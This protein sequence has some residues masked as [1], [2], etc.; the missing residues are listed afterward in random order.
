MRPTP[1]PRRNRVDPAL[2]KKIAEIRE[3]FEFF[4]RDN[5]GLIDFNEFRSL[6][7]TVNPEASIS[8][9]AEGFSMTD[10]NS[11][12]YVDLDEFIAWWRS[13]WWEY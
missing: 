6:L 2:D 8:Q 7:K 13:N 10:T 1:P 11:D 4:D 9:S 5:N 12:G 3:T